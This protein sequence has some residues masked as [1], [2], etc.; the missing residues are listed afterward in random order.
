MPNLSR[1]PAGTLEACSNEKN[2]ENFGVVLRLAPHHGPH[3]T[4]CAS[5]LLGPG[6]L[7][8]AG[9]MSRVFFFSL[10]FLLV[11]FSFIYP[12]SSPVIINEIA[13][14][15][16]RIEGIDPK[17]WWQYEWLELYNNTNQEVKISGW[18]IENAGANKG[19]L[20]IP[21]ATIL[22]GHYF[23]IC[24]KRL[25]NCDLETWSLSL[26]D[27]YRENGKLV[28]KDHK[29][30]TLDQTPEAN[31]SS[32]PAGEKETKR[33]M[34]RKSSALS[35]SGSEKTSWGTSLNAGGTPK[36][37]N[38]AIGIYPAKEEPLARSSPENPILSG[39]LIDEL[40][41]SPKGPDE[42]EEWIEIFN[43][44]STEVNLSGWI[45]RDISGKTN[46][47]TFPKGTIIPSYGFLVLSREKT[48]IVL[49]NEGDGLNLIQ[50]DGKLFDT[51]TYKNALLGKSYNRF[52]SQS[53]TSFWSWSSVLTPGAQNIAE[54][55]QETVKTNQPKKNEKG[56]GK[57]EESLPLRGTASIAKQTYN[58]LSIYSSPLFVFGI[59]PLISFFFGLTILKI[60][61]KL[62]QRKKYPF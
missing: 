4:L 6:R 15:G 51:V 56:S 42:T 40:L 59:A 24:K 35:L 45:I 32:W 44:N 29:G 5:L 12:A 34:E 31:D 39:I 62:E 22:P 60:K 61:K 17:S 3:F 19:V 28:L 27:D 25:E 37:P 7:R 9:T 48:K 55:T 8:L 57:T 23:L 58:Q 38:P 43:Q 11:P 36:K 54:V 1:T 49:N 18:K 2:R 16:S 14:M 21:E 33:T 46:S 20:E 50:P 47:Y 30:Q 10:L 53:G 13:W 26:K 41:P 52:V